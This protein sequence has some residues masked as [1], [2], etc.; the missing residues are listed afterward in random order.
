M[1]LAPMNPTREKNQTECTQHYRSTIRLLCNRMASFNGYQFTD[2][3]TLAYKL[4]G[5]HLNCSNVTNDVSIPFPYLL[6]IPYYK[7]V[8]SWF[9]ALN[10]VPQSS[11]TQRELKIFWLLKQ[12]TSHFSNRFMN[13]LYW[14]HK[15]RNQK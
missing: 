8:F 11:L 12:H 3:Y 7:I 1:V 13:K 4:W 9:C 5:E 14:I 15:K 10:S 6:M 2:S